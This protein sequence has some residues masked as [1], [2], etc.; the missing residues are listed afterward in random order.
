MP[1]LV[2]DT[3]TSHAPGFDL[4]RVFA[5]VKSGQIGLIVRSNG[6]LTESYLYLAA[7][8]VTSDNI[9]RL[10]TLADGPLYLVVSAEWLEVLGLPLKMALPDDLT[11]PQGSPGERTTP[12]QHADFVRRVIELDP[13][14]RSNG[15]HAPAGLHCVYARHGGVLASASPMAAAFDVVRLAGR[16]PGSVVCKAQILARELATPALDITTLIDYRRAQA[17]YEVLAMPTRARLPTEHGTF[18]MGVFEDPLQGVEHVALSLGDIHTSE[19]VLT[20]VH[21]ECFTGDIL[22]S[23]RCDCGPQLD[24]AL[25]QIG[26]EGRGVLLY[27]RQEG[28]GI[29][30]YNKMRAYAAQDTGLD[31]V[32]ANEVLGFPPDLRD[33]EVAATILRHLDVSDIRLLTN[34]PA[35]ISR[36][37]A[38][39]VRVTGRVPLHIPPN[40]ENRGYLATKRERMG[41]MLQFEHE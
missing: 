25:A 21:S 13:S 8:C 1:D 6:Y 14:L 7:D 29:G 9:A 16:W 39:G 38:A 35:K 4:E 30:L 36:L 19:P 15:R 20:R 24:L 11:G 2:Q 12:T 23:L 33:Y 27:L 41:H 22:G 28:R 18:T 5:A 32:Q 26:R 17:Q 10:H 31:T 3:A 37:C 40:R 34:N